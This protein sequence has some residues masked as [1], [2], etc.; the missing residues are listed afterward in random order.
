MRFLLA[1]AFCALMIGQAEAL[2]C[3]PGF[4]YGSGRCFCPAGEH[5]KGNQCVKPCPAGSVGTYPNCKAQCPAGF[6]G[7]PPSC[8]PNKC[9][10]NTTGTPPNCKGHP[11]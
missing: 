8:I 2:S 10:P 3:P 1:A 6:H 7:T 5:A 11:M 4:V 9:P